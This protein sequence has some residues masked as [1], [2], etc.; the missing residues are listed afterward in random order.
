MTIPVNTLDFI[1]IAHR[2]Q[3]YGSEPYWTHPVNVADTGKK[4]FGGKFSAV[5]Y[6]A[7]L[8]HDVVEDTKFSL[9]DLKEMG[10]PEDVIAAVGLLTKDKSQSYESNIKRIISSGDKN[11][12]MVKYSDNFVNFSGD[13]SSWP[14]KKRLDSQKKYAWSLNTLGA[15]LGVKSDY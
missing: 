1:K 3:S 10:Y 9:A 15:K 7:A 11:A 2:G 8:L 4:F 12:M 14:E 6:A 5:A 13:K